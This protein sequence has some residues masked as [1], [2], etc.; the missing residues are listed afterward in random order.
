MVIAFVGKPHRI[1]DRGKQVLKSLTDLGFDQYYQAE[2]TGWV[3]YLEGSTDLAI[4]QAFAATLEHDAAA[5][6]E[7]PYVHYVATNLPQRARDHFYGLKE[8]KSDF[9]GVAVFDHLEKELQTG[10]PLL[11]VMWQRR[12]VEN[13]LCLEQVLIKYA[14]QGQSEDLFSH[15][16]VPE[17]EKAMRES[18][19]EVSEALATLN[20]PG[21]WSPDLKVSDEFLDP[22]FRKY[23][24][25]LGLP[26]LMW[27]SGYHELARLVPKES[28]DPEV[29]EKLD[30]IVET[31]RQARPRAD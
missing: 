2:Q 7:R 15:A 18:I 13:Y 25:K 12:E 19:R 21:P 3:I 30:A 29:S 5:L 14:L 31:A 23:F 1:D 28:I 8:A 4:L 11:E 17:R 9:V 27:K 24:Q 6:L 20:M 22:L 10:T 26:N 16:E